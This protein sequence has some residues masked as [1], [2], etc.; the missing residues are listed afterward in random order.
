MTSNQTTEKP[1]NQKP[2]GILPSPY[3]AHLADMIEKGKAAFRERYEAWK[4]A[5]AAKAWTYRVQVKRPGSFHK[6]LRDN[7]GEAG[8]RWSVEI[9]GNVAMVKFKY[10][11]DLIQ[12]E[13][14]FNT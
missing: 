9:T 2:E 8:G 3:P 13:L 4:T 12:F 14:A 1:A 7:M 5:R 10:E 11:E 6:W